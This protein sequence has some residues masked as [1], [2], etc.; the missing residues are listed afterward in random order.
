MASV[1][2]GVSSWAVR[3]AFAIG[4]A[5]AACDA[6]PAF[7]VPA[8]PPKTVALDV[9]LP[10]YM[11]GRWVVDGFTQTLVMQ[12]GRYNIRVVGRSAGP[13]AVARVDLGQFTYRQWE[14]VDVLLIRGERAVSEPDRIRVPDLETNTLDVA[15]ELVAR[16]VAQRLWQPG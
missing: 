2:A 7:P 14:E 12:L 3:A 6:A 13:E 4:I 15:A 1:A 11:L 8:G 10:V 9:R 16:I 5:G